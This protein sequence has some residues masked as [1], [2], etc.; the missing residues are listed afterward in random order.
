MS[1]GA[2]CRCPEARRPLG[3]RLWRVTMRRSQAS[4]FAGYRVT[5]SDYSE[6][7]CLR[8]CARWRTAAAYVAGLGD[9]SF[10]EE[11]RVE[12]AAARE[13]QGRDEVVW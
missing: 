9:W 8:C 4:A 5:P 10:D 12:E 13:R 7:K 11:A 1:G 2:V 3:E 6:V